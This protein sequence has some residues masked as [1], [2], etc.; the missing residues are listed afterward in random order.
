MCI[1]NIQYESNLLGIKG[2]RK[3]KVAIP[4][5]SVVNKSIFQ[6]KDK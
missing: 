2:P 6:L 4:N 3:L 1:G 5:P